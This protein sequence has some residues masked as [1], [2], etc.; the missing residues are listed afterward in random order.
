[1]EANNTLLIVFVGLTGA[2]VLLQSLVLLGIFL[3]LR[4]TAQAV[5]E[6]TGDVK[7]T[8]IPLVHT[9]RELLERVSPQIMTISAGLAELTEL[10]HKETKGARVSVAD[11]TE[12]L[13]RQVKRIDGMLTVA[14]DS[15]EKTASTIEHSVAAPVRQVNGVVA[16]LKAIVDTYRSTSSSSVRRNSHV[17]PV[18]DP[19]R[20]IVI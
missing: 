2:A 20:D 16:A 9:T 1:M 12:R 11:I 4:K 7:G 5:T 10:V 13:N 3:S 8:M 14:L 6:V 15:V 17:N 18:P 19:D